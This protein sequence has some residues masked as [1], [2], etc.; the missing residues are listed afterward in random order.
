M[1]KQEH[2]SATPKIQPKNPTQ[3]LLNLTSLY[4]MSVQL[5]YPLTLLQGGGLSVPIALPAD[6]GCCLL[7]VRKSLMLEVLT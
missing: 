5:K 3:T 2:Q 7:Y 1:E 4:K 6:A